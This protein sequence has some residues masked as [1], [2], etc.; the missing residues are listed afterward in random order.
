MPIFIVIASVFAVICTAGLALPVILL[1][2]LA[3]ACRRPPELHDPLAIAMLPGR[4]CTQ[5]EVHGP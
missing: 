1:V 3:F 5:V 2:V 4:R